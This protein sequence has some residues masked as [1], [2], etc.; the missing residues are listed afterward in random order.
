MVY[1]PLPQM[2]AIPEDQ[3]LASNS[4]RSP[5]HHSVDLQVMVSGPDEYGR[6]YRRSGRRRGRTRNYIACC[7]V[8]V[9]G[10]AGLAFTLWWFVW[11]GGDS[12]WWS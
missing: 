3:S 1:H 11:K 12:S 6:R 10:A 7:L 4:I 8:S 5:M 2:P 9:A